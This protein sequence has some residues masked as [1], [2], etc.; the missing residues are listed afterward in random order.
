MNANDPVIVPSGAHGLLLFR[1]AGRLFAL[2][3][4]AVREIVPAAAVSPLPFTPHWVDG[5][6]N[7]GGRILPQASLAALLGAREEGTGECIIVCTPRAE[8]VLAVAEVLARIDLEDTAL[9]PFA[10]EAD[11]AAAVY[12]S[13]EFLHDDRSVLLLDAARL[14]ELFSAQAPVSGQPGL[15]G[16]PGMS[17]VAEAEEQLGCLCFLAAGERYAMAL[18]DVGEI[19]EPG[20]LTP[21]PGAPGI[22]AGLATLRGEPLL[23][24][25]LARLLERP[26][27]AESAALVLVQ[28]ERRIGLL[29]SAVE[30]MDSFAPAALR[31][32]GEEAG[33]LAGVLHRADGS[34][35]GLLTTARL[36]APA[37][38]AQLTPWMPARARQQRELVREFR[39]HLMV[40]LGGEAFGIPLPAVQRILPWQAPETVVAADGQEAG[41]VNLAGEVLPVLDAGDLRPGAAASRPAAWV[42][43]GDAAR[44]RAL[45]VDVAE[46]IVPVPV[47]AL[48][49]L[50]SGTGLV[51]AVAHVDGRLLAIVSAPALAAGAA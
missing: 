3:D 5:L 22:V 44:P 35:L 2:P 51:E 17:A 34:V 40:R 46:A 21:L 25:S 49:A 10:A 45:A 12:V 30:C 43:L 27:G 28:G 20:A 36:L 6:A 16:A 1:S 42:V 26:A 31:P 47:D 50:G 18:S 33:V 4:A 15:L 13:A 48:E 9:R 39:P 23:M 7:I 38:A 41:V 19:V 29:V 8:C 14:G 32:L 11:S 24:V 37:R